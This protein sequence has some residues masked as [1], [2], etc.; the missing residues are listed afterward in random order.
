MS[1]L[2]GTT[3]EEYAAYMKAH[4]TQQKLVRATMNVEY[5][6]NELVELQAKEDKVEAEDT[7][8]SAEKI[9]K[10]LRELRKELRKVDFV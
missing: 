9:V 7:K 5:Y 1:K 8:E 4:P 2:K 6:L 3:P 10:F